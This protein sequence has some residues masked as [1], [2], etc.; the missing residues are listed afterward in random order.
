VAEGIPAT[1]TLP[2]AASRVKAYALDGSGQRAGELAVSEG[3]PAVVEIGPA[4]KTL[5]Y[6]VVIR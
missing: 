1:I 2:V 4:H 6:E 3:E 5:W